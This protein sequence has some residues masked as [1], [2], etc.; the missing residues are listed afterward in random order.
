MYVSFSKSSKLAMFYNSE[1]ERL[2]IFN[3]KT[4]YVHS[5]VAMYYL[6]MLVY[7]FKNLWC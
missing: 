5:Y 4:T 7:L 2:R 1:K 6:T 3:K